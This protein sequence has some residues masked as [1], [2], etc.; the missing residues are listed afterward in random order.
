MGW[1]ALSDARGLTVRTHQLRDTDSLAL[2]SPCE[3]YRYGL[4]RRWDASRGMVLFLMLNPSTATELRNDPTI[5]RCERRARQMGCGAVLIGNLFAF[6]ATKP[7]D[8]KAAADPVG[9]DNDAV[10]ARW[11]EAADWTIAAWGV[12]GAHL[13]RNTALPARLKGPMHH[14]GLTKYGHP[15][16]PLYVP[17]DRSPILWER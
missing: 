17:Y 11:H 7:A 1:D 8:L 2:Y 3:T 16:H 14:L 9:P 13:G 15:R 12:H 4:A 10:V 6:R 5:E